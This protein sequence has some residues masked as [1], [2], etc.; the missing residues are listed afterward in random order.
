MIDLLQAIG[1]Q[2]GPVAAVAAVVAYFGRLHF[3][4]DHERFAQIEDKVATGLATVT[5]R[6]DAVSDKM[7]TNHADILTMLVN[8]NRSA[9]RKSRASRAKR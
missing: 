4:A 1:L 5:A 3:K 6:L 7:D 2:H 9:S 8:Q